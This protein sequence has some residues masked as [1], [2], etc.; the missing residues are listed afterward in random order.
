MSGQESSANYNA[1]ADRVYIEGWALALI[2]G[3]V[4]KALVGDWWAAFVCAAMSAFCQFVV[5]RWSAWLKAHPENRLIITLHAV[6]TDARWW[7]ATVVF[8]LSFIALSPYVEQHRWPFSSVPVATFPSPPT[9]DMVPRADFENLKAESAVAQAQLDST[10]REL[11]T[12]RQAKA[13]LDTKTQQLEDAKR[14][15][16][17]L[18]S[19]RD[20][21]REEIRQLTLPKS[22][23]LG[24]D[25]AKRFQLVKA[26][27]DAT[28][29]QA[30]PIECHSMGHLNQNSRCA[31]NIWAEI[32]PILYYAGWQNEG[33]RTPKT[34]FPPGVTLSSSKE[35]GGGFTCAFR[36]S[37]LLLGM[38]IQTSLRT[39]QV[40]PDLI[41]CEN[42]NHECVEIIIGDD[43]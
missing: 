36:L 13:Q 14:E 10:K 8:F 5:I 25:D 40:S 26:L 23:L 9:Q 42:E 30:H 28:I 2:F 37:E 3:T 27:R 11:E 39:N 20:A 17:S 22:T 43:R 38:H 21:Q 34:F 35:T 7:I 24:L 31:Q 32:S 16:L 19:Q 15:I 33:G 41:A 1:I 4:D 6:A 29:L 12:A 18:Q